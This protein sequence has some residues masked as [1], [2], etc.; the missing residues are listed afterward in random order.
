LNCYVGHDTT[1]DSQVVKFEFSEFKDTMLASKT[2]K[3]DD[4]NTVDLQAAYI[5]AAQGIA[6]AGLL[7]I[8]VVSSNGEI[9][10]DSRHNLNMSIRDV[11]FKVK[12]LAYVQCV[13]ASDEKASVK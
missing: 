5:P 7:E 8:Q 11:Y 10:A 13:P 6:A 3:L 12:G 1:K 4:G 2:V 9:L